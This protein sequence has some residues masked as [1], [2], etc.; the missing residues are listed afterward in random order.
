VYDPDCW[1]RDGRAD[2]QRV[3]YIFHRVDDCFHGSGQRLCCPI[4]QSVNECTLLAVILTAP[5][6]DREHVR[7]FTGK[8]SSGECEKQKKEHDMLHGKMFSWF[9]ETV[10]IT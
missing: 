9:G 8:Q 5:N 6:A 3:N 1:G 10:E 2:R 4:R 7:A